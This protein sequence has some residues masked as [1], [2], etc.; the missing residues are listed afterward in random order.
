MNDP[1]RSRRTALAIVLLGLI[2][3]ALAAQDPASAGASV[4]MYKVEVV[5]FRNLQMNARPEDPG[6]PPV[7]PPLELENFD[8]YSLDPNAIVEQDLRQE[9]A[10]DG[11]GNAPSALNPTSPAEDVAGEAL[12]FNPVD[13]FDLGELVARLRRSA[14]YRPLLHEAWIQP[15]L[16]EALTRPVSLELLAQVR[17]AEAFAS[18]SRQ[19]SQ[20]PG[21]PDPLAG[22][23]TLYRSRYLHLAFDVSFDPGN[24]DPLLLRGSRRI[25]SREM[26]FFDA[27]GLGA[28][29]LVTPVALDGA[30]GDD[31]AANLLQ[32]P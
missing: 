11:A 12:F 14:G 23:V 15:G 4:R 24:A 29:A 7:P 10:L 25:R 13:E 16:E 18:G 6:R 9:S 17:R 27:P 26:H 8:L 32:A 19:A 20:K 21:D 1:G 2:P 3:G 30:D 22:D 5:V 28:I 31:S